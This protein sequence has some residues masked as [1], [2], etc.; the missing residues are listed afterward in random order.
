MIVEQVDVQAW[1]Y[2]RV[3]GK[4]WNNYEM[5]WV[6]IMCVPID[7]EAQ[8]P[9]KNQVE[10][11]LLECLQAYMLYNYAIEGV[12]QSMIEFING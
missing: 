7:L 2:A 4:F 10:N 11:N 9:L 12:Q 3:F 8:Q 6:D 5:L 1:N